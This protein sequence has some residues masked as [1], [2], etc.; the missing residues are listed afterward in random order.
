MQ[1]VGLKEREQSARNDMQKDGERATFQAQLEET[2]SFQ[3]LHWYY[4]GS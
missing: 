3:P 2:Q 1:K 4:P